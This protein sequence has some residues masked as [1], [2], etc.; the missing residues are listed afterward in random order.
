MYRQRAGKKIASKF[1]TWEILVQGSTSL[2]R[3]ALFVSLNFRIFVLVWR[4][5]LYS[6][7]LPIPIP[8]PLYGHAVPLLPY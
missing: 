6:G 8:P 7:V 1:D 4:S 3:R 2:I 5:V